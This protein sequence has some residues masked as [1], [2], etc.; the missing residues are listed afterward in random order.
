ML[1]ELATNLFA[2]ALWELGLK[3]LYRATTGALSGKRTSKMQHSLRAAA[4][5]LANGKH[6]ASTQIWADF[7]ISDELY[8]LVLDLF[9]VSLTQADESTAEVRAAITVAWKAF[10]LVR[11]ASPDSVGIESLA[12][13]LAQSVDAIVQAAVEDKLFGKGTATLARR[14]DVVRERKA[15]VAQLIAPVPAAPEA[16]NNFEVGLRAE[17]AARY[18]QIEPPNLL[19]RERIAIERL[20]VTPQLRRTSGRALKFEQIRQHNGP[21]RR[22]RKSGRR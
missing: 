6:G 5:S 9:F 21:L 13:E 11:G 15:V 22:A 4:Q 2:T 17:V 10:A 1:L 3:P 14:S 7:L 18:S 12:A 20:F 8:T 16:Y 19:G